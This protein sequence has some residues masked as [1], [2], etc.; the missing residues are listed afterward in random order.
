M[1]IALPMDG[2]MLNQHFGRSKSFML[3]E[4]DENGILKSREISTENLLHNHEGLSDLFIKEG[5]STVI[6]G[7]MGDGAYKPLKEKGIEVIRG[8]SGKISKVLDDYLKGIL[9]DNGINCIHH[10]EHHK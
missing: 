7:G 8:A 10:G 1:K 2:H 6:A 9:E 3:A 5:V 4:V